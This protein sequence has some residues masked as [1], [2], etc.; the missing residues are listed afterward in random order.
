MALPAPHGNAIVLCFDALPVSV[1]I[2]AVVVR[3]A[4]AEA[5]AREQPSVPAVYPS[6]DSL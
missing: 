3:G 6:R 4:L 2:V 1:G 5:S